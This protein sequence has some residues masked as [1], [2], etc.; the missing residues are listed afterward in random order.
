MKVSIDRVCQE[1][2]EFLLNMTN[3][4]LILHTISFNKRI[5]ANFSVSW[6]SD[7]K[8]V[9]KSEYEGINLWN[10]IKISRDDLLK[11]LN[12]E[13]ETEIQFILDRLEQPDFGCFKLIKKRKYVTVEVKIPFQI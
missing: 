11:R 8:I 2:D 9:E 10:D 4:G 12:F 6:F 3:K 1:K 13:G 5:C 7:F